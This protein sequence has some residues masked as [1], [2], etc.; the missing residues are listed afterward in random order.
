MFDGFRSRCTIPSSCRLLQSNAHVTDA[1]PKF[2]HRERRR[3]VLQ[4]F[5]LQV[6]KHKERSLI[7]RGGMFVNGDEVRRAEPGQQLGFPQ[8]FVDG[9]AAF[10]L[11]DLDR[12]ASLHVQVGREKDLCL[13]TAAKAPLDSITVVQRLADHLTRCLLRRNGGSLDG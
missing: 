2:R 10:R 11:P 4:R 8:K 3:Q 6:L 1:A 5:A 13:R 7:D 9:E 12:D